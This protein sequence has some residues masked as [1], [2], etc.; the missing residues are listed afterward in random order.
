MPPTW[1][2]APGCSSTASLPLPDTLPHAI[3]HHPHQ[4]LHP[5]AFP[6]PHPAFHH[7]AVAAPPPA[8][9]HHHP[10]VAAAAPVPA[11]FPLAPPQGFAPVAAA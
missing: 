7:P 4:P 8:H 2:P 5:L 9:H 1:L 6:M 11:Q 3:H 10:A